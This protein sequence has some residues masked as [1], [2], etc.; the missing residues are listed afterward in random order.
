[1]KSFGVSINRKAKVIIGDGEHKCSNL[2]CKW[3]PTCLNFCA[4]KIQIFET[5]HIAAYIS[6]QLRFGVR[7]RLLYNDYKPA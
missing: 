4:N 2:S 6:A 3:S 7:T 5:M 1:M